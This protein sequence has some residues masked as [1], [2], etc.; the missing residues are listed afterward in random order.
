[1]P[2]EPHL[3][4]F[5]P[6][7]IVSQYLLHNTP[8]H[9]PVSGQSVDNRPRE[10]CLLCIFRVDVQRIR[11]T[12][13]SVEN[14]LT[15]ESLLLNHEVRLTLRKP[16]NRLQLPSRFYLT[17]PK[18][19]REGIAIDVVSKA[20]LS[21]LSEKITRNPI[22]QENPFALST[23]DDV[24]NLAFYLV[25]P[26]NSEFAMYHV[27]SFLSMENGVEREV[28]KVL[29]VGYLAELLLLSE[30]RSGSGEG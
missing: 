30:A 25:L 8:H 18:C 26:S 6:L 24:D 14:C 1:M 23:V 11:V 16:R 15:W 17:A 19:S 3:H 20:P 7:R 28:R 4:R 2:S 10:A 13:Q 21:V 12:V 5:H 27:E 9:R 29:I 22:N